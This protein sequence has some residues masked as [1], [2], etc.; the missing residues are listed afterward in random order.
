MTNKDK[1]SH[2]LYGTW[3]MMKQRCNNPKHVNYSYYGG[4]GVK[5]C[6]RWSNFW[7]FVEDVGERPEG[8]T[9]ERRDNNLNYSPSNCYWAS[10]SEQMK[11]RNPWVIP[12]AKG[13]VQNPS[14]SYTAK[15]KVEN[16]YIY[17]GTFPCPLLAH[18]TYKDAVNKKLSGLPVV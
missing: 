8:Y 13:Y 18:L 4:R 12:G 11:N 7:L 10:K 6:S 17:L 5:V 9:L 15:I 2:Y 14:G 1:S 16:K 3:S